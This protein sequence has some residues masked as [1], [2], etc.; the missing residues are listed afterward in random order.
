MRMITRRRED[1]A[2]GILPERKAL[3]DYMIE[4]ADANA[5]FKDEDIINEACTF[6]L[7]VSFEHKFLN[8]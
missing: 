1:R 3:L 4:V 5:D 6:M 8:F 2:N 7:A